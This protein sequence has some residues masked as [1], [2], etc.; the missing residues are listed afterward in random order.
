MDPTGE[1]AGEGLRAADPEREGPDLADGEP[2]EG[3]GVMEHDPPGEDTH[4]GPELGEGLEP[5]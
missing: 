5:C 2:R 3:A 4:P 1:K